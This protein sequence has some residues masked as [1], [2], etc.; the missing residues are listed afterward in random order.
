MKNIQQKLRLALPA[1]IFG[2]AVVTAAACA[3]DPTDPA[4][5]ECPTDQN[6]SAN[7]GGNG[8]GGD[9]SG[10]GGSGAGTTTET[11]PQEVAARLHGCRKLRYESLGNMLQDRGVNLSSLGGSGNSCQLD[12]N[13]PFCAANEKCYC[14]SP[15]CI[16]VGGEQGNQGFCVASPE[17]PGFLYQSAGDA[18]SFPKID[19][20][21]GEKDGHTSASAMRLFDIFIQAAPQIIANIQNPA[22][23]PAC[24]LQGQT[25]PMF[26]PADGS[27]VEE[28][29]SCL[30]GMR[31]SEDHVLLCNLILD[32]ANPSDPTDVLKKQHIAVAALLSAAHSCE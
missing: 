6:S 7:Q 26:D 3:S 16:Q 29:I 27:C 11:S 19:S 20:R 2:A 21:L 22:L 30:L 12:A 18:F 8:D 5:V 17:T 24:V 14:P 1:A 4:S 25:H 9:A 32:K 15:P 10:T 13:G 23:A 28:S 31:A